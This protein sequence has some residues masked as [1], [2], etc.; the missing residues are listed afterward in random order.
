MKKT[1]VNLMSTKNLNQEKKI[2]IRIMNSYGDDQ[3]QAT[4]EEA[5]A[6]ATKELE[7]DNLVIAEDNDGH[8]E[9]VNKETVSEQIT[10]DT[11]KVTSTK[12]VSGG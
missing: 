5:Q 2:E 11:K 4:V 9:Q 12:P 1:D 10:E 6:V 3:S 8:K 7:G